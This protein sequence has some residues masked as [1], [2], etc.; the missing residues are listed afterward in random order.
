MFDHFDLVA[1]IYERVMGFMDPAPLREH[2]KLPVA[3]RLLD[4]GGGT[5]RAAHALRG[6]AGEIVV[7]DVS[8]AMLR[9]AAEK[10]GVTTVLAQ[11]EN[12][13]FPDASFE[14]I[15]V[16]DAFHHFAD[17]KKAVAELWRV[18]APGGRLVIEEPNIQRLSIKLI[19]LAERLALM[20][21][22]F[23]SPRDMA[24]MLQAAGADA[25]V[26]TDHHFNSWVVADKA[27][28]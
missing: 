20:R 7:T 16:V 13:P 21:S 3:G 15:I 9:Q 4:A 26:D 11:V 27:A 23:F 2:L 22:T 19:A 10:E 18:L 25:H 12:L 24:A 8:A 6:L 5:G 1:P 17:H 14:R 28:P